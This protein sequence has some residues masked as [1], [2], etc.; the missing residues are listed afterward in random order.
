MSCFP[1]TRRVILN[2]HRKAKITPGGLESWLGDIHVLSFLFFYITFH[3]EIISTLQVS[4][5]SS[6]RKK[7]IQI[8]FTD[9]CQFLLYALLFSELFEYIA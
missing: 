6:K 8:P 2:F 7:E 5:G 4:C 9:I 1:I 3:F